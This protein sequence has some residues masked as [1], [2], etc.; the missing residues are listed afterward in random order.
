MSGAAIMQDL[1]SSFLLPR[2]T[3]HLGSSVRAHVW[4]VFG[5]I[6]VFASGLS[7]LGWMLRRKSTGR[8][9]SLTHKL[10]GALT[11]KLLLEDFQPL[12]D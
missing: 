1:E 9:A 12:P 4:P 7:I 11:Q 2:P 6:A 5:G 10:T 8:V 3:F